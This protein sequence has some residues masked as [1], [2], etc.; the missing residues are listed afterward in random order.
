MVCYSNE[1]VPVTSD[2]IEHA[3]DWLWKLN[4]IEPVSTTATCEAVVKAM[5]DPQVSRQTVIVDYWCCDIRKLLFLNNMYVALE[6][7]GRRPEIFRSSC[8]NNEFLGLNTNFKIG[9]FKI[10]VGHLRLGW[11]FVPRPKWL[12]Q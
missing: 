2:S 12:M 10:T 4:R 9:N 11:K 7:N 3:V 1:S 5:N 8:K 6:S